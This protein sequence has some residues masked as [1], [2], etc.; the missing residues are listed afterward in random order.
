MRWTEDDHAASRS[1]GLQ[2]TESSRVSGKKIFV[3]LRLVYLSMSLQA[4][5]FNHLIQVT[6]YRNLYGNTGE[7]C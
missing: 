7:G 1:L 6:I 5:S 4:C 3:P 2:N